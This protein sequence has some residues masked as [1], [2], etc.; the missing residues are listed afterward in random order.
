MYMG[1]VRT[2]PG[3]SDFVWSDGT[4][5][6]FTNWN[7]GEPS[8]GN[9]NCVEMLDSGKW[10]DIPSADQRTH[11]CEKPCAVT[12]AAPP[13]T[14]PTTPTTTVTFFTCDNGWS[15]YQK[16]CY[17]LLGNLLAQDLQRTNCHNQGGELVSIADANENAF[18]L[19]KCLCLLK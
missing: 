14:T 18:V 6:V 2:G 11:M 13:T 17:K 3:P 9:E 7:G 5:F 1:L 4:P 19:R 12:T 16:S 10:N 8:G 15:S